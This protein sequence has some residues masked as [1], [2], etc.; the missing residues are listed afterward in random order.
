M[1]KLVYI[2]AIQF[3]STIVQNSKTWPKN[4]EFGSVLLVLTVILL[5]TACSKP[6]AETARGVDIGDAKAAAEKVGEADKLYAE[7]EDLG[8][9]RQV[10]ALLRQAQVEDYGSFEAAWK[11]ARADYYLGDHT[12]DD[13]ERDKAFREGE[14]AG[15]AAVKLDDGK[16]EGHFWLG[17][18][19]GGVAKYSTLASLSSVEDIRKEMGAVLRL[20]EGF[21]AG[22]A[23]MVLGQLYLE[24][25]RVLGGDVQKAIGY[26]EKGLKFGDHNALLRLHLA[27][28]YHAAS[29]DSEARR[30]IDYLMSMKLDPEYQPEYK[31]AVAKAKKL[32]GEL[33][34]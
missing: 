16:P 7:R 27:L 21:Q 8:K 3:T 2:D 30:Q 22:S 31:E 34:N 10:V 24:A 32:L 12:A 18:N 20:N 28:A 6:A 11:L 25:P 17:A 19:Y 13:R 23:Y 15:N 9:L 33:K 4:Y 26:L 29:R 5:T 1:E 14:E